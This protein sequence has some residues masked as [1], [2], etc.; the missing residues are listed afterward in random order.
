M[1]TPTQSKILSILEE[2]GDIEPPALLRKLDGK[3]TP[4]KLEREFAPPRDAWK[5][6]EERNKAADLSGG[7]GRE[8]LK[9]IKSP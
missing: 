6:P 2:T 4:R 5:R 1:L 3:L 9:A 8:V 7:Y